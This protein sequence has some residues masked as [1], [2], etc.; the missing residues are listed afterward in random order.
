MITEKLNTLIDALDYYQQ[1]NVEKITVI[2][3]SDDENVI[4][5]YELKSN[6]LSALYSLQAL[7]LKPDDE[8]LFQVEDQKSFIILF[9]ACI[10]GGIIPVPVAVGYTDENKLKLLNIL[11]VLNKPHLII[12]NNNYLKLKN[13]F[14]LNNVH[15]NV[16]IIAEDIIDKENKKGK[17][18]N[19]APSDIAFI[20]FSSGSTGSPKGVILTHEN[21]ITNIKDIVRCADF[22]K[23]DSMLWNQRYRKYK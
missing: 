6:A 18:V 10:F 4:S 12:E 15:N 7:G 5:Y 23:K 13:Y 16:I 11:N 1:K 21:L 22:T 2:Y 19:R 17:I 3:G 8:L 9:W 14:S 20:Q